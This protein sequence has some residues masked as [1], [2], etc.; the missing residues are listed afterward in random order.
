LTTAAEFETERSE[1]F[2]LKHRNA[3]LRALSAETLAEAMVMELAQKDNALLESLESNKV[4]KKLSEQ[5][6]NDDA[7]AKEDTSKTYL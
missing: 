3:N 6:A 5:S 2:A 1:K 7:E 4:L